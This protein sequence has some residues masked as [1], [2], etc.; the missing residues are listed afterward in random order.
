MELYPATI[1]FSTNLEKNSIKHGSL[2][3]IVALVITMVFRRWKYLVLAGLMSFGLSVGT[4]TPSQALSWRDLFRGGIQ[5]LQ[6]VQLSRMSDRQEVEIGQ[7]INQNLLATEFKLYNDPLI[8]NYVNQIGQRL[9]PNSNR[10]TLPYTF[11]VVESDQI[12]AFATMGGF[13]YVTTGLM[14][15]ASNEAELAGVIGHEI[16]HI[17]GKHLIK[18]ISRTAWQQGLLTATGVDRSQV[19][20]LGLELAVR[21]PHSRDDERDADGRGLRIMGASGYAQSAVVSFMRKLE[22]GNNPPQFLSTH[23][24]PGSRVQNLENAI[25][26]AKRNGDGL[27]ELAYRSQIQSLR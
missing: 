5:V 7:Q 4:Q 2:L 25:D 20:Q 14:K 6:G 13:V 3:P 17:E 21:R 27:D 26:P 22:S 11:Q 8:Q 16:G 19:V 15:T 18:Q 1:V 9:V 12:N 24:S 10:S 23:P